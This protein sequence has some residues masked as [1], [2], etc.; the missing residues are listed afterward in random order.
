[1]TQTHDLAARPGVVQLSAFAEV[2][3]SFPSRVSAISPFVDQLMQFLKPLIDNFRNDDETE[4]DIE[5]AVREAISNAVVHGNHENPQK[6]VHVDCRC[7][8][9]GEVLITV[10]DEGEGFDGRAL[11]DPTDKANLLLTH[12]RGLHFMQ[13]LMDEVGFE[14]NGRIVRMRKRLRRISEVGQVVEMEA[15]LRSSPAGR[16]RETGSSPGTG[17]AQRVMLGRR[18]HACSES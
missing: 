1:M 14:D 7:T 12:G 3:Q 15:F 13:A 6:R 17:L 4:L 11:P 5:I 16:R 8:T 10:R 18:G 2:Q 9:D